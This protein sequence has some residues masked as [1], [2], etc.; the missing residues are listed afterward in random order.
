[1]KIKNDGIKVKHGFIRLTFKPFMLQTKYYHHRVSLVETLRSIYMM[2][3]KGQGQN[4]TSG[5]GHVEVKVTETG[6]CC[7]SFDASWR[8]KS[9]ET[10]RI[11]VAHFYKKLLAEKY[12]GCEHC[13]TM[14]SYGTWVKY[15]FAHNF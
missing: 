13:L 3:L 12:L 6:Q 7:I 8:E 5:Q 15:F 10:M 4:L 2:T 9:S 14:G 11:A 1:M